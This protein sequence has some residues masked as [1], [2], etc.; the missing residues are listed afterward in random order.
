[1][2]YS[3]RQHTEDA[4]R[5]GEIDVVVATK[6][7]GLGIDKPD[8]ALIV[9][10]EMPAS[11]EE[12]VQETGRAARG[13]GDGT[14]PEYGTAVLLVT[15]RDCSIHDFFVKSSV[16]N[17][18][19]IRQEWNRLSVGMNYVDP[20]IDAPGAGD[21]NGKTDQA[22]ALALH[23]LDQVGALVRHRDFVLRGRI[24]VLE[25][26]ERC[27]GDLRLRKPELARKAEL[28]IGSTTEGARDY[29]GLE[30][31]RSL[32]MSPH[33][34]EAVLFELQK[35][36]ICGFTGWR[37]GW[38]FERPSGRAPDWERISRLI[39]Q[40]Q[41]VTQERARRARQL[42]HGFPECRRREMLR[43]L[44]EPDPAFEAC[45]GCDA[46]TPDLPRPWARI[47][48]RAEQV[49]EAVQETA[50]PTVLMLIDDVERGQFSRRNLIRTLRGDGGKP[51]PLPRQLL[52]HGCFD[53]L[54]MLEEEQVVSLVDGLIE[55]HYIEQVEVRLEGR[56]YVTLRLTDDGRE[57]L[58]G[59]YAR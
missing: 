12:Y 26:T 51:Y 20:G 44:G 29:H 46:C 17:R 18:D 6:A 32:G 7:F 57:V 10:L 23:Y 33:E 36:N 22:K 56:S 30:A 41:K 11:I 59:R 38:V 15:P 19:D 42:S 14:G 3:E 53:R 58:H 1:M 37:Y 52:L 8:I 40:R 9:H 25:D 45:G 28:I 55:D 31:S 54:A 21:G 13:A 2:E 43:Y 16:P 34:I 5:H 48:I 50:L 39:R 4:F 49:R 47:D 24:S 35:Q 27:M